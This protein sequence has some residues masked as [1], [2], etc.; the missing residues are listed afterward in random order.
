MQ[1]QTDASYLAGGLEEAIDQT[2]GDILTKD[3]K[4]IMDRLKVI[5]EELKY[6]GDRKLTANEEESL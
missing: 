2:K 1:F 5:I 3:E 4:S 6:K